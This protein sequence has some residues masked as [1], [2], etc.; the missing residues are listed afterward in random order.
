M[1]FNTEFADF[2]SLT[3]RVER[4]TDE[5][6][7]IHLVQMR[8]PVT[9]TRGEA[10]IHDSYNCFYGASR[11]SATLKILA[12]QAGTAGVSQPRILLILS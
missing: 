9:F 1:R 2:L 5:L 6:H 3:C 11:S 10:C 12:R 7:S 4:Q 8:E